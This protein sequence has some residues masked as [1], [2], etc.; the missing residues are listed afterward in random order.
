MENTQNTT[1]SA[2]NEKY[3]YSKRLLY[4]LYVSSQKNATLIC[5][6]CVRFQS[7][8]AIKNV[9]EFIFKII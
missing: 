6:C 9:R 7:T 2:I 5:V 3:N 1:L 8:A 4:K